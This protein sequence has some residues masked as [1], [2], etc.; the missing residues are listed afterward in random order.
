MEA[1][2][3][4]Q[5]FA[6]LV[7]DVVRIPNP[8][9]T[10]PATGRVGEAGLVDWIVAWLQERNIQCEYDYSWGLHASMGSADLPGVLLS[11]HLDSDHL[12][13]GDC[14][15]IQ[16][17]GNDLWKGSC[18]VGPDDKTGVAICLSV[19]ERLLAGHLSV[20]YHVHVV[21]TVGEESGQKGA[22]RCPL[23]R[24]FG[25]QVRHALVIDRQTRGSCAPNKPDGG[26]LRHAVS[27]YK[28]VP[29]M[30]SDSRN[31]MVN[32]LSIA[33]RAVGELGPEESIALMQ[34]PNNAD[35]LEWRGRWDADVVAP[36]LEGQHKSVSDAWVEYLK[37]TERVMIKMTRVEAGERVSGMYS[38]PRI[39]RY[40]AMR[41]LRDAIAK[42]KITDKEL[43]FSTCNLSY[44]YDDL[45]SAVSLVELDT[46][47]RIVLGFIDAFFATFSESGS[48]DL[49]KKPETENTD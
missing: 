28:D 36:T 26:P 22:I 10:D 17:R 18:Q 7:Y 4:D 29:L 6:Q 21:F 48:V 32:C 19:I 24:L 16:I 1:A 40:Q 12:T 23:A 31:E 41:K 15:Y 2:P 9:D 25:R 20:P 5:R 27:R 35:A 34:S 39:G 3:V 44:D 14:H 8:Q 43:W 38:E 49:S 47:T 37:A 46:T 13:V 45:D 30:D 11:A 33:M 42:V